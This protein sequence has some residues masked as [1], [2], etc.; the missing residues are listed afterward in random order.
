MHSGEGSDPYGDFTGIMGPGSASETGPLRCFNG[1][2]NFQLRW[3]EDR[4]LKISDPSTPTKLN[5]TAFVDYNRTT[6]TDRVLVVVADNLYLQY[7][8]AKGLNA[9]TGERP[10]AL[11]V[12]YLGMSNSLLY[13]GLT[14][15]QQYT[16]TNFKGTG[17]TLYINVCR[18]LDGIAGKP[19]VMEIAIGY[20]KSWC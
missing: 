1:Y 3:Y 15:G 16:G 17:K 5:V 9:A 19:D 12:T 7:N 18:R 11:T 6:P 8:R 10:D 13:A 20:D 14:A 4:Q 2:K